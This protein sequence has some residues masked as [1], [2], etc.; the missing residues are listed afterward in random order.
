MAKQNPKWSQFQDNINMHSMETSSRA[1]EGLGYTPGLQGWTKAYTSN[2]KFKK[3]Q[4]KFNPRQL[5]DAEIQEAIELTKKLNPTYQY[6][7]F[8]STKDGNRI[9]VKVTNPITGEV[10]EY[11]KS[12]VDMYGNEIEN[13]SWMYVGDGTLRT[14]QSWRKVAGNMTV[15]G[16]QVDNSNKPIHS[17][18]TKYVSPHKKESK[19]T[20]SEKPTLQPRQGTSSV[21]ATVSRE[22]AKYPGNTNGYV[23]NRSQGSDAFLNFMSDVWDTTKEGAKSVGSYLFT[24]QPRDYSKIP[25]SSGRRN[26]F[27]EV[28]QGIQN[29][30]GNAYKS[31][32]GSYGGGQFGGGG[33]GSTFHERPKYEEIKEKKQLL[34]PVT[35]SR[36]RDEAFA[37]AR[38]EGKKTF[39]FNGKE[40]NT[41]LGTGPASAAH[42]VETTTVVV[43]IE[44][45]KKRKVKKE[46]K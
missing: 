46:D 27:T 13:P 2:Y 31:T 1:M 44:Y 23:A 22:S 43:P 38:K 20:K 4:S 35:T 10:A 37:Q 12:F 26:I 8:A 29:N 18:E 21:T 30:F 40:Y 16:R 5:T 11:A 33:A 25:Q 41:E 3:P 9:G 42:D 19:E 7:H 14:G 36:N 24:R 39:W 6:E 32:P 15:N 45:T 34:V 28:M 17:S